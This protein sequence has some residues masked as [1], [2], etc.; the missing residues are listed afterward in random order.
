MKKKEAL[1]ALHGLLIEELVSRIRNGEATPT[2]LNVARQL[3]RDNQID[4]AAVEGAPILKLVENLPFSDE[5][6]AA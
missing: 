6:E 4:C 1:E 5:E 2:D 3:L